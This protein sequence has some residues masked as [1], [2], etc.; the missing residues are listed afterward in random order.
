LRKL[1]LCQRVFCLKPR[2]GEFPRWINLEKFT[3]KHR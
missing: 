3:V 1:P 2:M